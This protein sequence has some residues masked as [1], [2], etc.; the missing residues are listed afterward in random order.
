MKH[1]QKYPTSTKIQ[2]KT[3]TDKETENR[4]KP[5]YAEILRQSR[6]TFKRQNITIILDSNP[7][8]NVHDRA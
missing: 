6:N 8:P 3:T 2:I 1:H 7:K 4:E 5:T